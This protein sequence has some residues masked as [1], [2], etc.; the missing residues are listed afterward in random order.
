MILFI[1]TYLTAEVVIAQKEGEGDFIV[2]KGE[3]LNNVLLKAFEVAKER[4]ESVLLK[5]GE[6][7]LR[8]P[9]LFPSEA[10]L[11]G[12]GSGKTVIKLK[13]GGYIAKIGYALISNENWDKEVGDKNIHLEGIEMYCDSEWP[14][15]EKGSRMIVFYKVENLVIKNCYFHHSRNGG[16]LHIWNCKNVLVEKT[17]SA[18]SWGEG[19]DA[20]FKLG[21]VE[22]AKVI[23]CEAH[24]YNPLAF[25]VAGSKNVVLQN[26][27]GHDSISGCWIEGGKKGEH[28]GVKVINCRFENNRNEGVGAIYGREVE[29]RDCN[30]KNSAIQIFLPEKNVMIK[31][32]RLIKSSIAIRGGEKVKVLDNLVEEG[33]IKIFGKGIEVK[34]NKIVCGIIEVLPKGIV[35]GK[36]METSDI[37]ILHNYIT[38]EKKD[39]IKV[40]GEIPD[41]KMEGNQIAKKER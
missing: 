2:K 3:I 29:I 18:Y 15:W 30:F 5:A 34:N 19:G 16:P 40:K 11:I 10:T 35:Y 33:D 9:F 7:V 37:L 6:Y 21:N 8:T 23:D 25:N 17:E 14:K 39:A 27:Y 32:N 24:H 13:W 36:K 38:T 31:N 28:I 1:P 41:L 4:G 20:A 26:C 12:E 22:N